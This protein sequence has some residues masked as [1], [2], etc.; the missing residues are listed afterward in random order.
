MIFKELLI[1]KNRLRPESASLIISNE[2]SDQDWQPAVKQ[3]KSKFPKLA[4]C[5]DVLFLCFILLKE[6]PCSLKESFFKIEQRGK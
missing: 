3:R 4:P 5:V 6:I 2:D 1:A